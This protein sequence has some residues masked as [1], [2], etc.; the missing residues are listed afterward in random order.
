MKWVT[1]SQKFFI[2]FLENFWKANKK[3]FTCIAFYMLSCSPLQQR[4]IITSL[5]HKIQLGMEEKPFDQQVCYK[6]FSQ[7]AFL[8]GSILLLLTDHVYIK[9]K[10]KSIISKPNDVQ[11]YQGNHT[12]WCI[13]LSGKLD[14]T[15]HNVIM[16][17]LPKDAQCYQ[18]N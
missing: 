1:N 11:C 18:G 5:H 8:I 4:C 3:H 17:I 13:M 15:M 16:K 9:L 14:Q 10:V 7:P 2:G 6:Y 12:K